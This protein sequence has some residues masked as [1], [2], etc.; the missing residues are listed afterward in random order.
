MKMEYN[1]EIDSRNIKKYVMHGLKQSSVKRHKCVICGYSVSIDCSM[2][3]KGSKLICN[4]CSRKKFKTLHDA[5]V[6]VYSKE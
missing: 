1:K 5:F 2:S 6:W 3:N 4:S